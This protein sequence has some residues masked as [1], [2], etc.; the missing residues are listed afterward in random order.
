MNQS[1]VDFGLT[2]AQKMIRESA[3]QL[4]EEA[5]PREKILELDEA[6]QFPFEA[7]E[8]M[9]KAGWLGLPYEV[10]YGGSEGSFKDLTIFIESVA[11]HSAQLASA[12]MTSVI[13]GGMQVRHGGSQ[14]LKA[15]ILPGVIAGTTRLALC[16]TEPETGSDVASIRTRAV[17]DGDDYV[18]TGQKVYITCAHVAHH[19]VVATKTERDAGH[20][21][22]TLFLVDVRSPGVT[23]RP[24]KSLGRRMIHTSEVYFDNVRV[25]AARMLGEKNGGWKALMRGLN[26]ER[27]G[28][29]AAA[30]GNMMKIIDYARDY[31]V[32]RTQ[33]GKPIS[34]Y[35]A[36][37]HK[38][39]DM[40]IMAESAR[41]M[42]HRV[43]DMLDA[44]ESPTME[45]AMAKVLATENNSRCADMG[46]QIMGGAGYMME[47][48]M[49][50]YFRDA[51]IGAIGGGTNE[52]MRSV[53]AKQMD[54]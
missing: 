40:Q 7:Y 6:R 8:A 33:F 43:A 35:Q 49:Q 16:L 42:T 3:L 54:L 11:Y 13:Y 39:A 26:L 12:Y 25:P 4:V 38:F 48:E 47:H 18:I 22:I 31:A 23:I 52:I 36:I 29:A 46:I 24:L 53:I 14:A 27:M 19:L 51:R 41:V 17:Q 30:C 32:E 50:M 15:E 20:K 37:A 10:E 9:A 5:L 44:G 2:E 28:L 34:S 45:T 1:N 21:G